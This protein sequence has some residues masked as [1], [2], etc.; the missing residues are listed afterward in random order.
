MTSLQKIAMGLVITLVD[1]IIA[2]YDAVP[3]V[4]GW[5]MVILGLVELR[6]RM[7]VSTL[8]PLAVVAGIVSLAGVRPDLIED[9][10]ESTG[11]LLSLPQ[12]TVSFLLCTEV[13]SL[14]AESL[15]RR[16]RV[17]RWFFVVAAVGPVLVY[18][19][20]LDVALVPLALLAVAANVYLVYLLFRAST[21]FH[22]PRIRLAREGHDEGP[23]GSEQR[24]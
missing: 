13:A 1:A 12:L 2:G 20:G 21:E 23:D 18:G 22:G 8:I 19:G 14:V 17:L 16:L 4:I 11:W 24:P 3:D 6:D 5:A 15:A 10:P 7:T 9:L